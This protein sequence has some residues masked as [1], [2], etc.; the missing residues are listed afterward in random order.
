MSR[1]RIIPGFGLSLGFTLAY[2]SAII[3]IPLAALF[4][5]AGQLG[6]SGWVKLL[7]TPQVAAAAKLSF[8][9]CRSPCRL[10]WPASR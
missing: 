5:K 8:G 7:T 4:I 3:L 9:A 2:L 1:R 6:W 10:P